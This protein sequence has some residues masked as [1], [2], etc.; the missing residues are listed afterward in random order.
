MMGSLVPYLLTY[1]RTVVPGIMMAAAGWL[2]AAGGGYYSTVLLVAGGS[3]WLPPIL[4]VKKVLST[5]YSTCGGVW[6]WVVGV[7]LLCLLLVVEHIEHHHRRPIWRN[8]DGR[9]MH[10]MCYN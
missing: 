7:R 10:K 1:F 5:P 4:L 3:G 2:L 8:H 6:G 9:L